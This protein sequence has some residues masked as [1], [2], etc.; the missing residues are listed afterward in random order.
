M[1]HGF[2]DVKL[3]QDFDN[4]LQSRF[5]ACW[6]FVWIL[7]ITIKC[8]TFC[9]FRVFMMGLVC[10]NNEVLIWIVYQHFSFY[11]FRAVPLIQT[12]QVKPWQNFSRPGSDQVIYTATQRTC[13]N[14]RYVQV[15]KFTK[16]M[17]M[18]RVLTHGSTDDYA[19]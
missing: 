11:S 5:Q 16:S 2:T 8:C 18:R 15:T 9:C 1:S 19:N 12:D 13:Q 4:N 17:L 6:K 10:P 3:D 7:T 14:G